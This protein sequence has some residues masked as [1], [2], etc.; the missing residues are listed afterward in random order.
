MNTQV[1]TEEAVG[2]ECSS[3]VV[4]ES[5]AQQFRFQE[6]IFGIKI[7][8]SGKSTSI[9]FCYF[10]LTFL[11]LFIFQNIKDQCHLTTD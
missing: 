1:G 7:A 4:D 3:S 9:K 2:V 8:L 6:S 5:R 10:P 11:F